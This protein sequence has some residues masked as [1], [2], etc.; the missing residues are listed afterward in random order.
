MKELNNTYYALFGDLYTNRALLPDRQY[1]HMA[2]ALMEAYEKELRQLVGKTTLD[3]ARAV[4]DMKYRLKHFVPHGFW[5]FRNPVAKMYRKACKE[6]LEVFLAGL[7]TVREETVAAEPAEEPAELPEVP[8]E[9]S[10]APDEEET[11]AQQ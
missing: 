9:E 2:A 5:I 6:A 11:T 7:A 3:T 1:K 8:D 4:Y 10:E